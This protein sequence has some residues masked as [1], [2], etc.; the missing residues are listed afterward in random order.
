MSLANDKSLIS[1]GDQDQARAQIDG[2]TGSCR[3]S[4]FGPSASVSLPGT[5]PDGDTDGFSLVSVATSKNYVNSDKYLSA[6]QLLPKS[7]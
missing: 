5:I 2:A 1:P 4:P 6:T 3:K 7:D